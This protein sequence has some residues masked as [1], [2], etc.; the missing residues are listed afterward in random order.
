M[1]VAFLCAC[2]PGAR[3]EESPASE[4]EAEQVPGPA[5]TTGA[6]VGPRPSVLDSAA[7]IQ[8]DTIPGRPA[9]TAQDWELLR[10]TVAWAWQ[11]GV[12]TLAI[13]ERVGR[14]GETFVGSVYIPA[15]LEAPGPEHLVVNLRALDCVTYVENMLVLAH[16]VREQPRD[17]LDRPRDAMQTYQDMLARIRYRDGRLEGYSSRLHYFSEWLADN[18]EKGVL[19]VITQELGGVADPEEITFMTEH[20]DAYRQLS[21]QAFYDEIGRIEQRLNQDTRYSIP[22]AGVAAVAERIRTGD[23]IAATSTLAGL[24]VAHTGIALWKDG[25]LHLMHAPLVGKNVEISEL[26]L[27]DRLLDIRAQDGIMVARPLEA[28]LGGR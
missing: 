11:N 26:P 8:G 9:W 17:V 21:D 15:T 3:D 13:G 10:W 22:E 28:P 20:R 23:V 2:A 4:P 27:A 7:L 5:L 1:A 12:D 18:E 6:A 24:D 25:A 14:I 16:F 19:D